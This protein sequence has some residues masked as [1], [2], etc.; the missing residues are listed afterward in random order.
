MNPFLR[1][2]K[3]Q[4]PKSE[5]ATMN[6]YAFTCASMEQTVL[7]FRCYQQR[8]KGFHK[9]KPPRPQQSGQSA[10]LSVLELATIELLQRWP[11]TPSRPM[12]SDGCT[13]RMCNTPTW[14]WTFAST[15]FE[16]NSRNVAS[17]MHRSSMLIDF[18]GRNVHE[19]IAYPAEMNRNLGDHF[20]SPASHR[21]S[22]CTR[23]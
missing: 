7:V 19:L 6:R 21:S 5:G 23:D 13:G 11:S 10:K 12:P 1:P 15:V 16:C 20:W 2:L 18:A 9:K 3:K 22:G 17:F 8:E 14:P 4:A